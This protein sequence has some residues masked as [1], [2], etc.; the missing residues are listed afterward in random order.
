M[1]K[2]KLYRTIIQVEVLSDTPIGDA[3]MDTIMSQTDSGDW[4]G[5]NTTIIQDEVLIGKK[6]ASAVIAQGSD[7]EFFQMDKNGNE[8]EDF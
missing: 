8:M 7:T 6:A 3:D 1:K 5:K 4:S 2:K